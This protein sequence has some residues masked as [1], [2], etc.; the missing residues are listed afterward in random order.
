M[1]R[2]TLTLPRLTLL[3]RPASVA[4]VSDPSPDVRIGI[5]STAALLRHVLQAAR[6]PGIVELM[7]QVDHLGSVLG[8][9]TMLRLGVLAGAPRSG[10]PNGPVQVD[11]EVIDAAGESV[12]ELLVWVEDGFLSTLDF[13]WWTDEPPTALPD[14]DRVVVTSAHAR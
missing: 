3:T 10:Y 5:E 11:A 9:V 1:P 8:P 6:V 13:A 2:P 4:R 14:I 7:A 12:G